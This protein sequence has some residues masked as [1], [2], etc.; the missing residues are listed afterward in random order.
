MPLLLIYMYFR[1]SVDHIRLPYAFSS[2]VSSLLLLLIVIP[3]Y[4]VPATPYT[5]FFL[6]S[7]LRSSLLR[8]K[9]I[10]ERDGQNLEYQRSLVLGLWRKWLS[11]N[12]FPT[13]KQN[14]TLMPYW[15]SV[16]THSFPHTVPSQRR[17]QFHSHVPFTL[18]TLA[19]QSCE[20]PQ[21][22]HCG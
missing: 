4:T 9:Q 22:S 15:A 2:C 18:F 16:T 14:V 13:M 21:R 17:T 19:I 5:P 10:S 12:P 1:A 7:P 8:N 11:N 20:L 6:R 3:L